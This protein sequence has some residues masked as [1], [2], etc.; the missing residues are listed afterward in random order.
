MNKSKDIILTVFDQWKPGTSWQD[1]Y[2]ARMQKT[3]LYFCRLESEDTF[4]KIIFHIPAKKEQPLDYVLFLDK[5]KIILLTQ[6]TEDLLKLNKHLDS[7]KDEKLSAASFLYQ[8]LQSFIDE[9]LLFIETLER[10]IADIEETILDGTI[11][12]FNQKIL[13]IKKVI[14]R[15]YRYYNQL[16]EFTDKLTKEQEKVLSQ[17][18]LDDFDKYKERLTHLSD[19]TKFIREYTLDVQQIYQAEIDIRQNNIMKILTIVATIFFP[20]SLI[21]GWYGM[22]FEYMPEIKNPYSYPAVIGVSIIIIIFCLI[23]FKKKKYW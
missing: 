5:K 1:F 4:Y 17:S 13:K 10:E 2:P 16:L 3:K 15:F 12:E 18:E 14:A 23:F 11:D 8:W 19:E 9:D 22:N 6:T 7:I 20:L 21:A